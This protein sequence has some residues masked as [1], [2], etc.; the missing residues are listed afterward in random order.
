MDWNSVLE[1]LRTLVD[2]PQIKLFGALIIL[3]LAFGVAAAIRAGKFDFSKIAMFYR[4]N[5][6]PYVLGYSVAHAVL[7]TVPEALA[8]V[9]MALDALAIGAIMANLIASIV[10]NAKALFIVQIAE[11]G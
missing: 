3:D 5:V 1:V 6:L 2:V 7:Q 11:V 4:T 9:G 8:V 10:K